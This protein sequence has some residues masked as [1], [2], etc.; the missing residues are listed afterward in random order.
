MRI[1]LIVDEIPEA[2]SVYLLLMSPSQSFV[3]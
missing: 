1:L 3:L 2:S